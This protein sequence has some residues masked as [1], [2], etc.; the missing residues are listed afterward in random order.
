MNWQKGV[1]VT[2]KGTVWVIGASSG[3]GLHTAQAFAESGW[4]VIAGARSFEEAQSS[5][6]MKASENPIRLRLDVTSEESCDRFQREA[7]RISPR[8]DVLVCGAAVLVLGSCELTDAGE[9]ERVMQTNFVGTVRMV[10]RV[11][12]LMRRNGGGKIILFSS[13]NGLLGVPFQSA[14][15]ASK[16]ALEGYAECL[17]M[18]TKPFG[19][20]VCLVEPGDH[21]GGSNRTRLR[22]VAED[23]ASPY[24]QA[25]ENACGVI[26]RDEAGGLAPER[27]GAKVVRN[28]QRRRMRFRLRIAKPDQHLAVLLHDLLPAWANFMILSD[29]YRGG[30]PHEPS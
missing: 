14:Y 29:Y 6:E 8:V 9:Y 3:L 27:L 25:Y 19:I 23:G 11:L 20:Q 13:I 2:K 7:L 30:K 18:E 24:C 5:F 4:L 26:V 10:G 28:A 17:A 22:A 12:P 1:R 16:H 21:R 15:T